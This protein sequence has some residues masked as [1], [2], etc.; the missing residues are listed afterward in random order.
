M[1]KCRKAYGRSDWRRR[2]GVKRVKK[3][4]R[5]C[6]ERRR[7]R[8]R[9]PRTRHDELYEGSDTKEGEHT[10]YRL[11]RQ[12]HQAGKDI[13][14]VRMI[15]DKDGKLMT[16]YE[17]VLRV[18]KGLVNEENARERERDRERARERKGDDGQRVNLD[19]ERINKEEVRET[20]RG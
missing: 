6:D 8:W 3:S 16:G 12:I 15:N 5:I 4:I 17:S 1:R 11:A 19:L 13:Q 14:Q 2:G 7:K 9:R 20:R 18:W 10:L